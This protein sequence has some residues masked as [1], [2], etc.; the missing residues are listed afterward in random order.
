[1][2]LQQ[3]GKGGSGDGSVS[4]CVLACMWRGRHA[5]SA[6]TTRPYCRDTTA[7]PPQPSAPAGSCIIGVHKALPRLQPQAV[8]LQVLALDAQPVRVCC[9][10]AVRRLDALDAAVL[11]AIKQAQPGD[12][13]ISL[14]ADVVAALDVCGRRRRTKDGAQRLHI[15]VALQRSRR[16]YYCRP[17]GTKMGQAQGG[18]RRQGHLSRGSP[19]RRVAWLL[20]S[21]GSWR[22]GART[23]AAAG[24][25]RCCCS[26]RAGMH[27]PC[28][29]HQGQ[30]RALQRVCMLQ[31]LP[32]CPQH[33]PL[34]SPSPWTGAN[35]ELAQKV[36]TLLC[37]TCR[38]SC[39]G[40]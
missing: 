15:A 21:R 30:P 26:R 5:R 12:I 32:C 33:E 19:A 6:C 13:A 11:L 22:L 17:G 10:G 4:P 36:A 29:T 34:A 7:P 31:L 14:P 20:Q 37:V 9:I 16:R 8:L 23:A 2:Q 25:G 1:M 40:V 38:L 35:V 18:H 3:A 24:S 28:S 27:R 39:H